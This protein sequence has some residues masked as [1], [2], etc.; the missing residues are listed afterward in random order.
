M[1][2]M[3]RSWRVANLTP[4]PLEDPPR[5]GGC[6]ASS[7]SRPCFKIT[8]SVGKRVNIN[9]APFS[10]TRP[11]PMDLAI[12]KHGQMTRVTPELAPPPELTPEDQ[13]MRT[14]QLDRL[15]MPPPLM[16]CF[17]II[18][19]NLEYMPTMIHALTTCTL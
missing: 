18:G 7:R 12:L 9:V 19:L 2:S 1:V 11:L 8:R 10:H 3:D 14:F 6:Q 13:T 5:K 15:T 4:A 16:E 17:V